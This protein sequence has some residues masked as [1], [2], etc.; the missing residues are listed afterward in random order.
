MYGEYM[1]MHW[2]YTMIYDNLC[3]Y[4]TL[5]W[6]ANDILLFSCVQLDKQSA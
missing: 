6:L 4:F 3:D 5:L 2:K 1:K